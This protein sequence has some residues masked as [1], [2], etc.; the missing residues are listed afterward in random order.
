MQVADSSAGRC[1]KEV[2]ACSG[3]ALARNRPRHGHLSKG[4]SPQRPHPP[5]SLGNGARS[6]QLPAR[7]Q[8]AQAQPR[9]AQRQQEGPPQAIG[10]P[11]VAVPHPRQRHRPRRPHLLRR[12]RRRL[13]GCARL[14]VHA[15]LEAGQLC[16]RK[17]SGRRLG[18]REGGMKGNEL[19]QQS[20]QS[21]SFLKDL[22]Q[23]PA[24]PAAPAL[25]P[26]T[27][28]QGQQTRHAPRWGSSGRAGGS[29]T[30]LRQ[31]RQQEQV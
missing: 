10:Q 16:R 22:Q 4:A 20:S 27:R 5:T 19:A 1:Q 12:Q 17:R 28:S 31:R 2:D 13:G 18:V 26:Q 29:A 30:S 23:P 21:N 8:A 9:M 3:A 25:P 11:Q 15:A 14:A 6:G 7:R 24:R